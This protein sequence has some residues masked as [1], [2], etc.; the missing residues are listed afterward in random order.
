MSKPWIA[1]TVVLI[2]AGPV[3]AQSLGQV[4]EKD[5]AKRAQ[6]EAS[7]TKAKTLTDDDLKR[8]GQG[9]SGTYNVIADTVK[10][11]DNYSP[12]S[13]P[14]AT[15]RGESY[16]RAQAAAARQRIALAEQRVAEIDKL[17]LVPGER[18]V[19]E[20]GRP[21]FTD[22]SQLQALMRRAKAERDAA[23][24]AMA[25]LEEEAR[26]AGALPGWLR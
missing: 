16:W 12:K 15:T 1:V 17:H 4:A 11:E 6:A 18:Y 22:R 21:L 5:K 8:S 14:N 2:A 26:R 7:G 20:K 25:D 10:A 3:S 24:K 23:I 19:D 13:S 9:G